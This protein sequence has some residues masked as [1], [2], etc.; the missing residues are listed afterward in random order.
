[1]ACGIAFAALPIDHERRCVGWVMFSIGRVELATN[2]LLAPIARYCDLAFRLVVRPLGGLGLACTDLV[3]P[4][5][6]LR[7][8]PKTCQLVR[9][10]AADQPLAIQLY[11]A[12]PGELAEAARW[13]EAAGTPIVDINMGCPVD[14]V[15]RRSGGSALLRDI[16]TAVR[17]A[18]AV[19]QAVRIPVTAKTRL[20]WA[21]E[22]N[23]APVLA[24]ALEDVGVAAV[25]VHA[26][27]AEARF[28]GPA[29]WQ[30]IARVVEAVRAIPVIGN[31]D[32]RC[33]A[34]ARAM[35]DRT[36]CAG[37]MIGR[38]ALGDPWIFRDTHA[39][40]TTGRVPPPPTPL[41]R[42]AL[43]NEHFRQLVRLRGGDVA[44]AIFRQRASWYAPR[45]GLPRELRDRI[46]VLAAEGEYWELA[47]A[48]A[49]SLADR[50]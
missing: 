5:A 26:R 38:A 8:T 10:E 42:L 6:L 12:D 35:I 13:C 3:N 11:G 31:G 50:W 43:M 40:L 20:G 46:R 29:R 9:T 45:I 21:E 22:D 39:L 7:K 41:E 34:D 24:R 25:T 16:N 17:V 28:R 14:K 37:V 44:V 15:C 1:M 23:V 18:R 49:R 2:L 19:V 47:A 36:G 30:G 33:P 32:V 27:S 48:A 4:R